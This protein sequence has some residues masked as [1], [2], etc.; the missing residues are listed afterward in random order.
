MKATYF[1]TI[2][3]IYMAGVGGCAL[4]AGSYDPQLVYVLEN[5]AVHEEQGYGV[6]V[7][8]DGSYAVVGAPQ[9]MVDPVDA[10]SDV[11]GAVHVYRWGEG[12]WEWAQVL[13]PPGGEV[14]SSFGACVALEG[15]VL[16]VGAYQDDTVGFQSGAVHLYELGVEGFEWRQTLYPDSVVGGQTFGR[17]VALSGDRLV[18]GVTG[19]WGFTEVWDYYDG[20]VNLYQRGELGEWEK[21]GRLVS[22]SF[23]YEEYFGW[24]ADVD[25][26]VVVV[27][28]PY[29]SMG[30]GRDGAAYVYEKGMGG[31]GMAG[32]LQS[33]EPAADGFFGYAMSV[34]GDELVVGAP[35]GGELRGGLADVFRRGEAG[36][37]W[38]QALEADDI[39]GIGSFGVSIDMVSD[40]LVI[41]S[42][43]DSV[44]GDERLLAG[45][46]VYLARRVDGVWGMS[47]E[48]APEGR[49]EWARLGHAVSF[50]GENLLVGAPL[51]GG[52]GGAFMYTAGEAV[53]VPVNNGLPVVDFSR[54]ERRV[55]TGA[56]G[57]MI[58]L[59]ASASIDPDG[60]ALE[61]A[62][63]VDGRSVGEGMLVEVVLT[64]GMHEVRLVVGD[65]KD[66][67]ELVFI[68]EVIGV[69]EAVAGFRESILASGL[70]NGMKTSSAA[71][72]RSALRE[73]ERGKVAV[74]LRHLANVQR[75]L[76]REE[77]SDREVVAGLLAE[78]RAIRE[79]L[80]R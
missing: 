55:V 4:A 63:D 62:W 57:T 13:R 15:G 37:G 48:L 52:H 65:G 25:G 58:R 29:A 41:G 21:E 67:V 9:E 16:A 24:W 76:Y 8:V 79:A 43:T 14:A 44:V 78:A 71:L 53:Q 45:G 39:E 7:A 18:V 27:G 66:E 56:D 30:A 68:V 32:V 75:T 6:S 69:E 12:G 54:T 59:D 28:A 64:V 1:L 10:F 26:D 31:W 3:A 34:D 22:P 5:P 51:L 46:S 17:P 72:L 47:M 33:S 49:T 77:G 50:D 60:D 20:C 35:W 40:D 11:V 80:E 73:L 2:G 42:A 38:V 74:A 61:F 36:W 70:R 19:E 23:D